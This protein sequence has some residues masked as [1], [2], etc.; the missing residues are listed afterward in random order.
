MIRNAGGAEEE[1]WPSKVTAARLAAGDT[2][3]ITVPNSA[4][5]GDP[6]AREPELVLGDVLDGFT[7]IER[8]ER[9]YG[10]VIEAGTMSVD[11]ESSRRLRA[12][13]GLESILQGLLRATGA[14]RIT[15]R[16]DVPGDYAFPVTQEALAPGVS[17]LK[18]ERTVDLSGQPVVAE[19]QQ[20]RQVVQE[21]SRAAYDDPAYQR[22]LGIYGGLAAQIVTPIFV[23]GRLTAIVSLHQ[24]GEP[25]RWTQSEIDSCTRAADEVRALL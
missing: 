11:V 19:V 1:A 9:D 15:L 16:Q 18:A 7:T 21:D 24:L 2:L 5:Y 17:S 6:L 25:R 8:A 10:V 4:G 23:D 20:G 22:M 3:Q 13:R 14:S 12:S